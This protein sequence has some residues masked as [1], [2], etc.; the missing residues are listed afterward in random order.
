MMF[1]HFLHD[2]Q[3]IWKGNT[4]KLQITKKELRMIKNQ[5]IQELKEN[6]K[7]KEPSPLDQMMIHRILSQTETANRNNQTRTQA[8]YDIYIK[9]PEL[10][11]AFLAHMVSRNGGWN[12][13]DLKG[14]L[15]PRL[16]NAEQIEHLFLFL[17]RAN[18][19]IFQD[20]YPQLV[21]Y[22]ESKRLK[23][24]LFHLLKGFNV[25][26][27]MKPFWDHFWMQQ[28]SALLSTALIINEQNYIENRVLQHPEFKKHVLDT[29]VFKTQSLLQ[30]NQV[31]FPYEAAIGIHSNPFKLAGL[32]LEDFSSLDERI[33][34]GKQLYS[35][36]FG[37]AD[38]LNGA[39]KFADSVKHSGSRA[40]YWPHLF[41]KIKATLP[42]SVY[43]IKIKD[44]SLIPGASPVFS[45]E[46]TH[47]WKDRR[48]L[49]AES[50]D[51]CKD[52]SATRYLRN[53]T[54]PSAYE[55]EKEHC[56]NWN[57][58]ELAVMAQTKYL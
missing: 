35:I 51:W 34:F 54:T 7:Q 57:K 50:Y 1:Q 30:L 17:E 18:S 36:L 13:T 40:D 58:I 2:L 22:T 33:E 31:V 44:C 46:L 23:T 5:L 53:I 12:M 27:W 28:N 15:L 14:E 32:I 29:L 9:H 11:W 4:V 37:N 48:V 21:L 47:V 26:V 39:E 25:S 42:S 55:M 56:F 20:A 43:I 3:Q 19:L 49:P 16:L 24:N 41:A 45:P 52:L 8:Y 10:H 6:E 38:I